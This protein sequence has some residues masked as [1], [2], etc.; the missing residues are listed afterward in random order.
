MK[1][2]ILAAGKGERLKGVVDCIPKPMIEYMGKPL[3]RHN[4]ELCKKFG[5]RELFINT[6]H[7]PDVIRSYF[8][9]GS[10]F[11]V[12]IEYSFE[13]ELL[14][15]AGAL[16]NFRGR[17]GRETFFVVYGDNYCSFDLSSLGRE[18]YRH[19][20][21]G[22]IGFYRREDVSQSGVGEFGP[23]GRIIRFIEKP[24]PGSTDSHW[25]NA[26]FY[27]LSPEIFRHIPDGYSD[28]RKGYLP[29]G[30]EKEYT[31]VR[32]SFGRIVEGV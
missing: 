20:C 6:H 23:D 10:D 13:E 15:T 21:I 5:I 8:G 18:F 17:I 11:G 4:V 31:A 7:L 22:V 3:L 14:G 28:F 29:V 24:A 2:I 19:D 1:A 12:K 27:C 26:G 25:V 9:D 32:G 16:N 30:L